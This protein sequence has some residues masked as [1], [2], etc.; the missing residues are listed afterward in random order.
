MNRLRYDCCATYESHR[1]S[2]T[3]LQHVMDLNR[4]ENSTEC[5]NEYGL[6]GGHN[7]STAT[8]GWAGIVDVESNLKGITY[9]ATKCPA[10]DYHPNDVAQGVE[11][12]KP[13]THSVID[14]RGFRALPV[15]P[16]PFPRPA[17][18]AGTPPDP[19]TCRTLPRQGQVL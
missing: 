19:H 3:P 8:G 18:A 15:C 14:P 11:M 9:P 5:R 4:F 6:V 7:A 10:F 1:I 13:V 17:V 2:T 16:A 12:Y